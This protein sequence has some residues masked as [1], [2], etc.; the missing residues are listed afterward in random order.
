LEFSIVER[1]CKLGEGQC[2][3]ERRL[4][5][6]EREIVF[7]RER[8]GILEREVDCLSRGLLRAESRL[9]DESRL[10]EG[11]ELYRR[12]CEYVI[13][14]SGFDDCGEE[15]SRTL[16]VLLLKL[17]ADLGQADAQSRIGDCFLFGKGCGVDDQEAARY[18][19][20]SAD[21]GNSF[22]MY[23]FGV[24]LQN[25]CG[26]WK[27]KPSGSNLFNGR[28]LRGTHADETDC[29]SAS[30]MAWGQRRTCG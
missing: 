18:L 26:V 11:E 24:C 16:G 30:N 4:S 3:V 19:R 14:T 1:L 15:L 17:S 9:L 12:M 25:G 2:V 8:N 27:T 29:A 6:A 5:A 23:L 13:E 7:L 10:F 22:W 28:Q 21:G 20:Q